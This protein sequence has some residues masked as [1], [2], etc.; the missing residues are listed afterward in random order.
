MTVAADRA[1]TLRRTELPSVRWLADQTELVGQITRRAHLL[2]LGVPVFFNLWVLRGEAVI[3]QNFNDSSLHLAMVRWARREIDQGRIPLDGWYPY[4]GMGLPQFHRYQ[5]LP[6][7]I[8]AYISLLTGVDQAFFWSLYLLLALWPVSVY[9]GARLLGWDRWAAAFAAL[10]SPLLVSATSYGYEHTSYMW[11]GLGMWPQL[12]GMWLLPLSWGLTWRAVSG[13]GSYLPA[14]LAVAL[15]I[16]C[17]LPTGYLAVLSIGVWVVIGLT[18]VLQ[19]LVRALVIGL[20]AFLIGSWVLVPLLVDSKW[21]LADEFMRNT[22]WIDSYGAPKVLGWLLTGQIYDSYRFPIVSLLVA[23][24]LGVCLV[25]FRRDERARALVA[26]WALSLVLFFGRPTLGPLVGVLP[27]SDDMFLPRYLMGVHLAGILMAGVGTAWLAGRIVG[28]LRR[29]VPTVGTAPAAA[30]A[31]LLAILA[32]APAWTTVADYDQSRAEQKSTQLLA[33]STD[34]ADLQLLVETART[35]GGGRIYAGS[36][37]TWG[38]RYRVGFIPAFSELENYDADGVGFTLR[39][40]SL[41]SDDE[42]RFNDRVAAQYDLFNV[43]YLILPG[44]QKPGVPAQLLATRGRHNLWQVATSGYLQV[45]DTTSP[46]IAANRFDIGSQTAAFLVSDQLAHQRYPTVAFDGGPAAAP[47]L[48]FGSPAA[49]PAGKV[50]DQRSAPADGTFSGEVVADRLAFVLLKATYD[51][52]WK[53]T[54]DGVE[55]QPEMVAPAYVGRT[56]APGRHTI[57]FTYRRYGDYPLLIAAGLL[58]LLVL[59]VMPRLRLQRSAAPRVEAANFTG[60]KDESEIPD[61]STQGVHD[62]RT[63]N[64]EG[65]RW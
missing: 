58:A 35:L 30:G 8:T 49:G 24:G 1:A 44:D 36:A 29:L 61:A 51:P 41:M 38:G 47:T 19:R 15:T 25:T 65:Y 39:T 10:V 60:S 28:G 4:L 63:F 37:A 12:W 14:S 56:V 3:V 18:Q 34:G 55:V 33:E 9:L 5:S 20:G 50:L 42:A 22:F 6:H 2:L 53:V 54:L 46:P 7:T 11:W 40:Y 32:L 16:A 59:A 48:A 26:I 13:R 21:K 31:G 64:R 62:V 23:L 45:V 57:S 17:H 52:R 43:R 27:A